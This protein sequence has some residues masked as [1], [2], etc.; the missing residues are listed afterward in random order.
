MTDSNADLSSAQAEALGVSG[1]GYTYVSFGD[2]SYRTFVELS[3]EQ[4]HEMLKTNPLFPKTSAPSVGDFEGVYAKLKGDEV[5]SLHISRDLSGT[6]ASAET[7]AQMMNGDPKIAIVDTRSIS[8]GETLF[9]TEARRMIDAGH[10]LAEIKAAMEAMTSRVRMHVIF[11][12]LENLKRGGR[13]SNAQAFLGGLLQ[14]KPILTVKNGKLEPLE[15]V[16]TMS[17]AV[18]RLKEIVVHDLKGVAAP[19]VAIIHAAAPA[20][21]EQLAT[22][23]TNALGTNTPMVVEAGPAIAAHSGPGAIGVAY[24]V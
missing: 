19:K 18:A 4:F 2:K 7:A 6:I 8:A 14:M 11:D 9:I 16:R 21:A 22:E 12:T 5:I 20:A 3:T 23:L 10:S 15:R 13:A 17:K 24:L 1:M